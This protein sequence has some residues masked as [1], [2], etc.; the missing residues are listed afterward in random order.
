MFQGPSVIQDRGNPCPSCSTCAW[1]SSCQRWS[2]RPWEPPGSRMVFSVTG[3][4]AAASSQPSWSGEVPSPPAGSR[5]RCARGGVPAGTLVACRLPEVVR[6]EAG[7]VHGPAHTSGCSSLPCQLPLFCMP[8]GPSE[9]GRSLRPKQGT[10]YKW[11]RK[12]HGVRDCCRA[13]S[14][15]ARLLPF[16]A[17]NRTDDLALPHGL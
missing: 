15:G 17:K 8:S 10:N 7:M 6:H 4:W 11:D 1:R 2:G 5:P 12:L 9:E 3:Q 13:Q 16:P 14:A